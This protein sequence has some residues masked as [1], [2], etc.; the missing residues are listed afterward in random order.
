MP[1]S[2]DSVIHW[3]SRIR[4]R[5]NLW[6]K[7]KIYIYVICHM[8]HITCHMWPVTYH[9]SLMVTAT[10]PHPGNSH[11][12]HSRLVHR[13]PKRRGKTP[14]KNAKKKSLKHFKTRRG[15]ACWYQTLHWLAKPLC[16]GFG[17][18]MFWRFWRKGWITWLINQFISD[19]GV[20]RTA[21]ATPGL[22]KTD[23]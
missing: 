6:T 22:F 7:K 18:M 10:G 20:S 4:E 19:G 8:S 14:Q 13:D 2:W 3:K 1:F 17:V 11:T 21:P 15:R 9:Q 16:P 12:M 23:S 5:I